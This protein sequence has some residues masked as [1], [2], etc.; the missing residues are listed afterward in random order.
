MHGPKG[1]GGTWGFE[2]E[3]AR[4]G[5]IVRQWAR[6]GPDPSGLSAAI[7]ANPDLEG[8]IIARRLSEWSENM[9]ANL[10]GIRAQVAESASAT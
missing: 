9:T 7:D 5:V 4:T 3:P 1:I 8:R 10:A 6:M 2:V